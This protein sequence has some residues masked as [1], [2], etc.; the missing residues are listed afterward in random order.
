MEGGKLNKSQ[1]KY[2]NTACLMNVAL[3]ALLEKKIYEYITVKESCERAGVNRSTF[4][5][6]YE[7]IDDLLLETIEYIMGQM[8][9]KF[10]EKLRMGRNKIANAPLDELMLI[11]PHYLLPYLS[12]VKENKRDFTAA[13]SQPSVF[14]TNQMFDALNKDV[15][16]PILS[17]YG[18]TESDKEY[19]LIFYITGMYSVIMA[20]IKNGCKENV[21]HIAKL[22]IDFVRPYQRGEPL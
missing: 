19:T 4:Y 12:F 17:R 1:S 7:T 3:I 18:I 5:L 2:Y 8:N 6:H 20:W 13:I 11:T 21:E 14:R 9:G 16:S 10:S 22:L 15:F